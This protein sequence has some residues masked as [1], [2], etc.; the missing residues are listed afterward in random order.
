M[1]EWRGCGCGGGL[2]IRRDAT[3]R[4]SE[5]ATRPLAGKPAGANRPPLQR[6]GAEPR[7]Q[8]RT[9][10]AVTRK[11]AEYLDGLSED[12]ARAV[13]ARCCSARR[14]VEQVLAARP[15]ASDAELL[16]SAERFWWA[17]GR[18]DWLEA[19]AGHPRI[20]AR[21][22]DAAARRQQAGG[23]GGAGGGGP[24]AARARRPHPPAG[25]RVPRGALGGGGGGG[26][27]VGGGGG[28][29]G[30]GGRRA[31]LP[32]RRDRLPDPGRGALP[33]AAPREPVRL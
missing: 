23:G 3:L 29:G 21:P 26:G 33:R 18:E 10:G 32:L 4:A 24:P 20:G 5:L 22:T 27:G 30:G 28:G 2:Q 11:A 14:W 25:G 7:L 13:L 19:F 1:A 17:L 15:F 31:V 8:P 6:G 9:R 16:E 12:A